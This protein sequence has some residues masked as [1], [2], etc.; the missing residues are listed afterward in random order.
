MAVNKDFGKLLKQYRVAADLTLQ[1][2]SDK[3]GVSP[4]HLG[5]IEN[6][7]RFPSGHILQRIAGPLGLSEDEI[8]VKAG[9]L[10]PLS[11]RAVGVA[12]KAAGYGAAGRLDP[13]VAEV[14][15]QEPV[16]VQRSVVGILN[17][18]KNIAR[19]LESGGD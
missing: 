17:M 9:Y 13:Y 16:E 15:G 3:A 4:S 11:P 7:Q 18:L 8:F 6:S 14:L 5:R 10:S 19:G 2:L 1:E 12:E